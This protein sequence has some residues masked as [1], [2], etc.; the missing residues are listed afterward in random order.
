MDR[1]SRLMRG[2]RPFLFTNIRAGDG[3]AAVAD[4]VEKAGGLQR[5]HL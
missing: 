4:F 2:E 5:A 3:V 1:D